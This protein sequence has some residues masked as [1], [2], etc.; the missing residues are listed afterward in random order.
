MVIIRMQ[1]GLGNQLFQYALCQEFKSKGIETKIDI[2]AYEDGR[3]SRKLELKKL[4]LNPETA[5]RQELHRYFADNTHFTDRLFRYLFGQGKYKKEKDYDFNPSILDITDG[6]LSGYWQS[7]KYFRMA[8][9]E[10]RENICFQNMDITSVK[11]RVEQIEGVNA[12]SVHVR[13]G[14]YLQHAELYGGIC[15]EAYYR[16]AIQYMAEHVKD[17]VFFVFSDEPD[18]AGQM[19]AGYPCHVVTE[20]MGDNSYRDM[21]LMSRCRYHIIA[22]STFSWWGAW[23]DRH[24]DKIVITPPKWNHL[25]KTHDICCDGWI[26]IESMGE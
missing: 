26:M 24:E 19:L 7:E 15:T 4:G 6:F 17:P 18:R 10:V 21:Y 13:Q 12:V 2:S 3:E 5:D 25:C 1:G 16:K 11:Q 8:A 23:L 20:N 14:D 9:S 22:N